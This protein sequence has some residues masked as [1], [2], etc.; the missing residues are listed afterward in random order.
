MRI[1]RDI[2]GKELTA[3][4]TR[5]GYQVTRQTGSH[6]RITSEQEPQQHHVTIPNHSALRVGTISAVLADVVDSQEPVRKNVEPGTGT[7]AQT[8]PGHSGG[9][10]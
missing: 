5:F 4:L 9:V 6:I 2:S 8:V 3:L 1:P 10:V 7:R